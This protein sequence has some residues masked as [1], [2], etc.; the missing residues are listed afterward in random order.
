VPGRIGGDEF[1]ILVAD[2][3]EAEA[4]RVANRVFE[5]IAAIAIPQQT[6]HVSVGSAYFPAPPA[7]VNEALAVADRLMYAAKL[8][9]KNRIVSGSTATLSVIA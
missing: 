6:V 9:G 8:A 1:A 7:D 3:D 4:G 5:A 2:C